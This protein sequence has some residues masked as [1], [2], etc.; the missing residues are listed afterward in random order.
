MI[1]LPRV[2]TCP[3]CSTE[4][5]PS[6]KF[7]GQ[8]GSLLA[9][10]CASCGTLNQPGDRFCG[11]CGLPLT[12]APDEEPIEPLAERRLVTVL[13]A[14]L[15]GFTS[16]S[17][18]RDAEEVRELLTLYF[19]RSREIVERFG[20][21]VEKF[22]G[23]A[24]MAVWGTPTTQEDDAERAVRAAL[25]LVDG[26]AKLGAEAGIP[27]LQLRAGVL[28][29]KAAVGPGENRQGL[30]AGD[31]VNTASRLQSI[32]DPGTVLVGEST[33]RA[34]HQAV[35]FEEL[36]GQRL[37]GKAEPV[38]A[39]RA[40]WVTSRRRGEGKS[41]GLEA[42]FAGREGELRLLKELLHV[43]ASERRARVAS[44]VGMAGI[45]KSRL[46]WEF[47]KYVDGLVEKVYWHEGR[48]P[49]YGQGATFWALGEMVRRRAG[50]AETEEAES[51]RSKLKATVADFVG[52]EAERDWLLPRLGALLG[53]EEAPGGDRTELFA[54]WRTFFERVSDRGTTVL[55]FEDLHW[56]DA[57]LLDFVEELPEWSRAKPI[58]VLTLARPELLERRLGWRGRRDFVSL[59][60]GPLSNEVMAELVEG[61]APGL[62]DIVVDRVVDRAAGVPL[63]AVEL[64][65]TLIADGLLVPEDGR[66]RP[67]GELGEL[68]VPE[69]L[70]S[71][72]GAR[73]DRLD[74]T[75]R[76]LVQDAS[77][78]GRTFAPAALQALTGEDEDRLR[79][80][81]AALVR[82]DLIHLDSDP[83]SPER[84]QYGF[85]Q[86][87][88]REVAYGRVGRR[89]RKAR[90][91][92]AARYFEDLHDE[93]LVAV[94]A[95][96]YLDA[97][98]AAPEGPEKQELAGKARAALGSAARRAA[99][100][101][102]HEQAVALCERALGISGEDGARA[103]LWE[104]A[105]QSSFS[106]AKVDQA[107][108]YAR[109]AIDGRRVM[110]D[111]EG[112]ARATR[113]LGTI[114]IMSGRADRAAEVLAS[115]LQD[116]IGETNEAAAELAAELARAHLMCGDEEEAARTAERALVMAERLGLL[117]VIVQAMVTRGTV[118]ADQGRLR[119]GSAL[120][121]ESLSLAEETGL[122][123]AEDRA[124]N[125]LAYVLFTDDPLASLQL[126]LVGLGE[127]RRL[128]ARDS[129][130]FH[131]FNV[132][133]GV[134]WAGR[135]EEADR[136]LE[137]LLETGELPEL[138]R[139]HLQVVQA[140]LGA[141]RGD[142]ESSRRMLERI[143]KRVEE[144]QDFQYR[145]TM[146]ALRAWI[147]FA[148]GRFDEAFEV[149]LDRSRRDPS[150]HIEP[151]RP[152]LAAALWM[153]GAQELE[154]V[155]KT[156]EEQARRGR[157]IEALARTA[158][159]GMDAL[160]GREASFREAAGRWRELE[161]PVELALTQGG[162]A[163]LLGPEHPEGRAAGEEARRIFQEL[164]A[165]ALLG[166]L[167]RGQA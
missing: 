78:L 112:L 104:L 52:E 49:A 80:R 4:N 47:Q 130:V 63:Y 54:A 150:P 159:A 128:R 110:G 81:L 122:S 68:A 135:W 116:R 82:R 30:V 10:P 15:V 29:G 166:L 8:C 149:G 70:Q 44:I 56:A 139:M 107:E 143:W 12:A 138:A 158:Q 95:G 115:E 45:G 97:Y 71:V 160:S 162:F 2:V 113:I 123:E 87:L 146:D 136:L 51:A 98:L 17:E 27:E 129:E 106:L 33:Y 42:P 161:L 99:A 133:E 67:V 21:T 120:L 74:P 43:T 96:H 100:L 55:V 57:G 148:G 75:E 66:Y 53:L 155:H 40:L 50:I 79:R 16:Y 64:I 91:L 77:V 142:P 165:R 32:A 60:L 125:N 36:G 111:R 20:G 14:D 85:V 72:I 118:L 1:A 90:H 62:S 134:T 145:R 58:L 19:E 101:H 92:R 7:C 39:W 38:R 93:E 41:R 109:E 131:V 26:V 102:S 3:S 114:L 124:R 22:I 163:R 152:A 84:G 11:E 157:V 61:L 141:F 88:V 164:G 108:E 132:L 5:A 105:A 37:R 151:L 156:V 83:R 140:T 153:G 126:S 24:V 121:K 117:P 28:T 65:R 89:E 76:A 144:Q 167:E 119:E 13:F 34:V 86:G 31:L 137:E 69:T 35:A 73:L 23:D 25:E 94:V 9:L 46:V 127:A 103:G 6:R 48:S 147:A 59:N 18:D 154:Q